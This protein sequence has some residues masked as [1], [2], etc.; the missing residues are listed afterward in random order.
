MKEQ[1]LT[2]FCLIRDFFVIS[3]SKMAWK[4]GFVWLLCNGRLVGFFNTSESK[5]E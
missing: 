5:M 4:S 3:G 2:A 1:L